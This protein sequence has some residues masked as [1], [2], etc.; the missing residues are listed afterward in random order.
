[1]SKNIS[2]SLQ[3][4]VALHEHAQA[5]R[6][7]DSLSEESAAQLQAATRRYL[8]EVTALSG[9][10]Q[11]I[12]ESE[13]SDVRKFNDVKKEVAVFTEKLRWLRDLKGTLET[14]CG[15]LFGELFINS[16]PKSTRPDQAMRDQES[17]S[18]IWPL[19]PNER[20]NIYLKASENDQT[21]ML[22]AI[23]DA[24]LPLVSD[25]VRLR[26]DDARAARLQPDLYRRFS[27]TGQLL[28]E[29]SVILADGED[30]GVAFG[31]DIPVSKDE[32]GPKIRLANDFAIDHAASHRKGK[33]ARHTTVKDVAGVVAE[34]ID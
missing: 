26:A 33:P 29:I 32:L 13:D 25:E 28:N 3:V 2:T 9:R 27:E 15:N 4:A 14:R 17:R 11:V 22:R 24:P 21:E 7:I 5:S 30:L 34:T 19:P 23:Q 16:I 31:L 6:L 20:D 18:V 1:M 12:N 8:S 10:E